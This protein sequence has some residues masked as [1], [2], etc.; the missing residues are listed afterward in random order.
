M[1]TINILNSKFYM[2]LGKVTNFFMLNLI[3][4]IACIPL[5]TIFPAI[6]AMYSVLREW[7][8][9]KEST[10]LRPFIKHF[11]LNFKQSLIISFFW[12]L[13]PALLYFDFL[14]IIQIQSG[15]RILF[16][17]PLFLIAIIFLSMSIFLFPIIVHYEL[18]MKEILKS[19]FIISLTYYPV[20]LIQLIISATFFTILFFIPI[21]SIFI[22][23]LVAVI[24]FLL[25]NRV[26]EKLSN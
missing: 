3:F 1:I 8:L 21:T 15:W 12:L 19:T 26:F 10:V 9:N 7:K 14:F 20:T 5:V 23:S 4:L 24:N 6:A 16:L 18:T 22:F 17:V 11:K 25:C 13:F 2:L